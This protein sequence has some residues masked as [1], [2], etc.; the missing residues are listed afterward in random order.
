MMGITSEDSECS[1]ASRRYFPP[2]YAHSLRK[3]AIRLTLLLAVAGLACVQ[4]RADSSTYDV[5]L[6]LTLENSDPISVGMI[7]GIITINTKGIAYDANC[8]ITSPGCTTYFGALP[9]SG[10]L[11][12]DPISGKPIPLTLSPTLYIG[13]FVGGDTTCN[14]V[15]GAFCAFNFNAGAASI[16]LS[17]IIGGTL[18]TGGPL[19]ITSSVGFGFGGVPGIDLIQGS[20]VAAP[21][22]G[23]LELMLLGFAALA[24]AKLFTIYAGPHSKDS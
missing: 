19:D 3:A 1:A 11:F 24:C 5:S 18:G 14:F 6:S 23:T 17:G 7:T 2:K 10:S 12:Y 4:V 9:L 20:A 15:D 8:G 21:E 22:S 13:N 16:A